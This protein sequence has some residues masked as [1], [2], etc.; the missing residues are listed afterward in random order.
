[1][2]DRPRIV[3]GLVAFLALAAYPVW[4]ALASPAAP[5]GP[6]LER[7]VDSIGCIE[8]TVWMKAHH[9]D[10]L[11]EWRTA[12]VRDGER[13]YVS[14]SGRKWDMNLTGTCMQCHTN[15]QTFCARCHTYASV[16]PTCWNCHVSP[17]E[18]VER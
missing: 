8:D 10:L 16:T 13:T 5:M 3:L 12:V 1:M 14:T 7:A 6:E 4:N 15:R 17:G 9:A 18:E 2:N 11:N